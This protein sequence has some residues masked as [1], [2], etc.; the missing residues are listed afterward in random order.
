LAAATLDTL[1]RLFIADI[2]AMILSRA[3]LDIGVA[4]ISNPLLVIIFNAYR[5][6]ENATKLWV[7]KQAQH[8]L[9]D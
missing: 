6:E 3:V 1:R 4:A 7:V 2:T 8:Q 9:G 5:V